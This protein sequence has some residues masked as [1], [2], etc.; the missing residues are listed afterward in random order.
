[1]ANRLGFADIRTGPGTA[2][3]LVPLV[4]SAA[5]LC[6]GP[7]LYLRGED[8]AFD[9][10]PPLLQAGCTLREA[11]VYRAVEATQFSATVRDAIRHGE[12]D[13]VVLMSPRT[14]KVYVRLIQS[15]GL[16][17]AASRVLHVCLSEN[18][19]APLAGLGTVP[20]QVAEAP[21][22]QALLTLIAQSEG[23]NST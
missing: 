16:V 2:A 13:A 1:M 22:V 10:A 12:V 21:T 17:G 15:G 11:I 4:L 23:K 7:L 19:A 18:V 8:V 9:L 14:S 3:G 20:Q 6:S 5:D